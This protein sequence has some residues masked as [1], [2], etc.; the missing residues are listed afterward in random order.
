MKVNLAL[1]LALAALSTRAW[2]AGADPDPL[3]PTAPPLMQDRTAAGGRAAFEVLDG[4]IYTNLQIG[5][6][7]TRDKLSIG[8]AVPLRL[9]MYDSAPK[10]EGGVI[11]KE[12]WDD[13]REWTR[14]VRYVQYGKRGEPLFL[15]Y[16]ELVAASIGHGTIVHRYYNTLDPDHYHSGF[17]GAVDFDEGGGEWITDDLLGPR[18]VGGRVY[19]RPLLGSGV[20]LEDLEIGASLVTDISA[21]WSITDNGKVPPVTDTGKATAWLWALD[22]SHPI[23]TRESGGLRVY[24]DFNFAADA[25][26]GLHQGFLAWVETSESLTLESRL[27]YRLLTARYAPSYFNGFYDFERSYFYPGSDGKSRTKWRHWMEAPGLE[28]RQ[29]AFFELY[30]VVGKL[31]GIGAAYED[32]TR[33][34]DSSFLARA[35]LP[36][37]SDFKLAAYYS[38]RDFASFGEI[39]DRDRAF[40]AVEARYRLLPVVYCFADYSLLWMK[41]DD[42]SGQHYD[43]VDDFSFGL[44]A[45]TDF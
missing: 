1:L 23:L 32:Y 18:I 4:D 27:E 12:E 7:L 3:V 45:E 2:A 34:G 19:T 25:G 26:F 14:I 6:N 21:P 15:R 9:R 41:R 30:S 22:V 40:M 37:M 24:T 11:R 28:W 36:Y 16:G 31:L 20:L 39:F 33:H 10:E 38:K 42:G 17:V 43:T 29:G 13:W 35:E 8:L 44:G 5:L